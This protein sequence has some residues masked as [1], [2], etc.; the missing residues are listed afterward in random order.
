MGHSQP[1]TLLGVL[2]ASG[3]TPS[4]HCPLQ[5]ILSSTA[6]LVKSSSDQEELPLLKPERLLSHRGI[7]SCG[8]AWA[9]SS[10]RLQTACQLHPNWYN[11]PQRFSQSRYCGP[12]K[13]V[14][15]FFWAQLLGQDEASLMCLH[16]RPPLRSATPIAMAIAPSLL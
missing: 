3:S 11:S 1:L 15:F 7:S 6:S 9:M 12:G 14:T 13:G 10:R 2:C 4:P 8:T 5:E 16:P